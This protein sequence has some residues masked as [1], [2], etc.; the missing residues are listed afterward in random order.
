[1]KILKLMTARVVGLVLAMFLSGLAFAAT[2]LGSI[3]VGETKILNDT[4]P[5]NFT[6]TLAQASSVKV[7]LISDSTV[8]IDGILSDLG[9]DL[10]SGTDFVVAGLVTGVTYTLRVVKDPSG[11]SGNTDFHGSIA[12]LS[13]VPI[14]AAFWLFGSAL[15][16]LTVVA[17]R[18]STLS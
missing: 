1:M 4:T 3:A 11:Q 16:G 15:T 10:G 18:K 13:P 14:P 6:F 12:S 8:T 17:R 9:G 2:D 5:E 7:L